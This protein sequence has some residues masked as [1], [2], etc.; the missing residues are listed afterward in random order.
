M[1]RVAVKGSIGI[2][3]PLV[4]VGFYSPGLIGTL[5][6]QYIAKKGEAKQIGHVETGLPPVAMIS[7]G[8]VEHPIRVYS[9]KKRGMVIISSE[10]PIPPNN[11]DSIA[12]SIAEW[13]KKINGEIVCVEGM[14]APK[15]SDIFMIT[16]KKNIR[17]DLKSLGE[18]II[19]GVTGALLL[20]SSEMNIPATCIIA[21]TESVM[22]DGRAS[23]K[24]IEKMNEIFNWKVDTKP[25]LK[26]TEIFEKKIK[27][28]PQI[29]KTQGPEI[30][31]MYG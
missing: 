1:V 30:S 17:T 3:K 21:E 4:L 22:P 28:I 9:I 25:L 8:K 29:A 2:K 15:S 26:E 23:A 27:Q 7:K 14:V 5:V 31:R 19:M 16:S 18:G 12:K 20:N 6:S 24:V 10:L 11:A 13:V